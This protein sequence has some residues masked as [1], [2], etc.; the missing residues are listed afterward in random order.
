MIVY[1]ASFSPSASNGAT[2]GGFEWRYELT[3]AIRQMLIWLGH[4]AG[5]HNLALVHLEVPDGLTQD[6]ITEYLNANLEAV[7]PRGAV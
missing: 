7:E 2:I 1:V 5:D 4:E 6:E 3:D